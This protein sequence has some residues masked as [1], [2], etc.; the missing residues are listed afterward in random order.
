MIIAQKAAKS[1]VLFT[2]E[3]K[4]SY[5]VVNNILCEI[6]KIMIAE[7]INTPI[8]LK[9]YKI[10][11]EFLDNI[12]KHSVS[13]A[14]NG[15]SPA[16]V[17][18]EQINENFYLSATNLVRK[19]EAETFKEKINKINQLN[20]SSLKRLQRIILQTGNIS[21]KGG[22]GLGIVQIALATKNKFVF[23][24][25]PIDENYSF[26]ELKIKVIN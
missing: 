10:I 1:K 14:I 16:R 2:Y 23:I 4:I 11:S 18:F 8:R 5:Q 25:Q 7:A 22:A 21:D 15:H 3:G 9:T 26:C 24:C 12:Q 6:D 13:D 17:I 20:L 19:L